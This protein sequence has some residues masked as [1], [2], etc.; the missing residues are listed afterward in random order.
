MGCL[1]RSLAFWSGSQDPG[2]W[3]LFS[4]LQQK[5]GI[6][7]GIDDLDC[8]WPSKTIKTWHSPRNL[9]TEHLKGN[10]CYMVQLQAAVPRRQLIISMWSWIFAEEGNFLTWS[11]RPGGDVLYSWGLLSRS[12]CRAIHWRFIGEIP[13][14]WRNQLP[15]AFELVPAV[16]H[17]WPWAS[18][19]NLSSSRGLWCWW[20]VM[21]PLDVVGSYMLSHAIRIHNWLVVWNIFYFPI[22]WE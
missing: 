16:I 9:K 5:W 17:L 13:G 22:Y 3:D 12:T 10:P 8:C 21:I 11:M 7:M 6:D 14:C 15:Q 19:V 2:T 4:L 1:C 18:E 20:M